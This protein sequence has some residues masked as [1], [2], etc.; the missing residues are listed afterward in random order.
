MSHRIVAFALVATTALHATAD[1]RDTA[2]ER[3]FSLPSGAPALTVKRDDWT[4]SREQRRPGDTAVY[5]MLTS[6]KA[7]MVL[8]V[9]ID[10]STVCQSSEAC[11]AETMKNPGYSEAKESKAFESGPFKASQFYLD[12]P[13]GTSVKQAHV[14]AA[15]YVDGHWF[16]VHISKTGS[17]RPEI[18]PLI[19]LL[20]SL[21]VR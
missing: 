2:A 8:S 9:Y 19:E 15:A 18:F 3:V 20:K 5:Y 13:K 7:Q 17:E 14:L 1:V 21:S 4:I 6:E 16:D 11:L 12:K 10:K